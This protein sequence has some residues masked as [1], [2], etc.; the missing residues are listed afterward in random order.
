MEELRVLRL[1]EQHSLVELL[2]R[3]EQTMDRIFSRLQRI[4]VQLEVEVL[5][6]VLDHGVGHVLAAEEEVLLLVVL[7]RKSMESVEQ[8]LEHV[9]LELLER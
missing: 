4:C 9:V 7:R 6:L 3:V 2:E 8:R 1:L 5:L